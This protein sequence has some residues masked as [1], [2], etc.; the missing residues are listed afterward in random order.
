MNIAR[1][2]VSGLTFAQGQRDP[3]QTRFQSRRK[4][5]KPSQIEYNF[6]YFSLFFF[7]VFTF[8]IFL[9][10]WKNAVVWVVFS[11][12]IFF[13]SLVW[14][15]PQLIKLLLKERDLGNVRKEGWRV[16]GGVSATSL[17]GSLPG[18]TPECRLYPGEGQDTP[19]RKDAL[20]LPHFSSFYDK[21]KRSSGA[22]GGFQQHQLANKKMSSSFC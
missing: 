19:Q 17:G 13:L 7:L 4:W 11:Y 20:L 14:L 5:W 12:I 15:F 22:K 18:R 9:D 21:T 6:S 1:T 8:A 16:L 10:F 3:P 2:Y